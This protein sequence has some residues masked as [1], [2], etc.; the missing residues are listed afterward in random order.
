MESS[1]IILRCIGTPK[2]PK[3]SL[4]FLLSIVVVFSMVSVVQAKTAEEWYTLAFEQNLAGKREKA[5]RSYQQ[6]LRLK[7]NWPQAHHNLALLF[8][9]LKNGV[10]AVH[11]LRLAEKLSR[12]GSCAGSFCGEGRSH[13]QRPNEDS[14]LW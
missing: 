2:Q 10:M 3:T 11:H 7:N 14:G 12:I 6:V 8:Y 1:K 5:I 9:R 13:V 4:V